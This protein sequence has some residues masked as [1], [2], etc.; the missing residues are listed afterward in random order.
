MDTDDL[1]EMAYEIIR[2]A[3]QVLDVLC[4]EIGTSA[5]NRETEDDFLRG[6]SVHLRMILA[7]PRSYLDDWNYLEE[8][9]FMTF[10]NEV[11]ELFALTEKTLATPYIQRSKLSM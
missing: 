9:D 7:S 3:D 6:V 8:F 5:S 1:S 10:R 2:R 4:A 11:S